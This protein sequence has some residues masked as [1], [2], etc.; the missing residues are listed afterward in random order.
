MRRMALI[1]LGVVLAA[2]SAC[3]TGD[4]SSTAKS[5]GTPK[6]TKTTAKAVLA[7]GLT[8]YGASRE[9]WDANHKA[10]PGFDPGAAFLPLVNGK[11]PHYAGVTGGPG[12][13]IT[14]YEVYFPA[15]TNM[16]EAKAIALK[17]APTG[18][19]F[20]VEDKGEPHCLLA[21]VQS[22]KVEAVMERSRPMVAFYTSPDVSDFLVPSHVDYA[23]MTLA[24]ADE[25]T[26]LGSC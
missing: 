10:A 25:T 23:I 3:G 14:S 18:A 8:G 24:F 15:G 7:G 22:P 17:E 5:P 20:G 26:D 12:E 1:S 6:T 21:E 4:G 2:V 16:A 11:Q 13:R 9:A 19:K